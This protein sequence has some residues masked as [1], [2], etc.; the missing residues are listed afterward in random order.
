[1]HAVDEIFALR[2]LEVP[3]RKEAILEKKL[4]KG[5]GGWSRHKEILGWI[6]DSE[7]GTLELTPR[8][9]KRILDIFEELRGRQHI[10]VKK[11][12]CVLGE[13]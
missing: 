4:A 10:G 11:W 5:D 13:L 7:K 1:M 8:W 9:A 6:L 3:P 12:Q 2:G